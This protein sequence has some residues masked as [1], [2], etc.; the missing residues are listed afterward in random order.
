MKANGNSY[1]LNDFHKKKNK[2]SDRDK[3]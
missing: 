3:N 1:T 2:E